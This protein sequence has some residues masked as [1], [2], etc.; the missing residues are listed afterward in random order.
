MKSQ[1]P[2]GPWQH[3]GHDIIVKDTDGDDVVICGVGKSANKRSHSYSEPSPQQ[4]KAIICLIAAA[5]ELLAALQW[6][7]EFCDTHE[8]WTE[9]TFCNGDTESAEA[10]WLADAREVIAKAKGENR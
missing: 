5:P 8:E 4:I 9:T 7:V 10:N 2:P 1:Y 6:I 3:W